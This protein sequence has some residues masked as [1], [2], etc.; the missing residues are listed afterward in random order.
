MSLP[1]H[2]ITRRL[3]QQTHDVEDAYELLTE[4]RIETAA[5]FARVNERL[6]GIDGRLDSMD[7]RLD[8]VDS[9]LDSMDGRLDS[10]GQLLERIL[11]LLDKP[12][13]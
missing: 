5:G 10:H 13:A 11:H 8:G 9:R 3:D 12:G 6:G 7:S 2:E 1:P 4:L